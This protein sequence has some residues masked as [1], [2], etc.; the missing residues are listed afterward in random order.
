LIAKHQ[1]F[2]FQLSNIYRDKTRAASILPC[3]IKHVVLDVLLDDSI[4]HMAPRVIGR[5][6]VSPPSSISHFRY[7]GRCGALFEL[8]FARDETLAERILS[9]TV[10]LYEMPKDLQNFSGKTEDRAAWVQTQADAFIQAHFQSIE[11]RKNATETKP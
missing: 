7:L 11:R 10:D 9:G 1:R 8:T 5:Q 2:S 3:R 4:Q 6:V